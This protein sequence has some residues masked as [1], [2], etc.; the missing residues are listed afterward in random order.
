CSD[1]PRSRANG[2][3]Y[4]GTTN[5]VSFFGACRPKSTELDVPFAVSYSGSS[6]R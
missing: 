4:D 2:F 3:D 5:T 6:V 1:I